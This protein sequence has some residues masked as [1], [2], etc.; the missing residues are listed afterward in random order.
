MRILIADDHALFRNGIR[1]L[2][3]MRGIEV[4]GEA[5][6]GLEA[7]TKARALQPDLV[8]MDLSMPNLNGLDATRVLTTEMP[9]VK[10]VILT[11]SE[12][13]HDLFEAIKC[14]AT[15][16]LT[17]SLEAET[18]FALLEGVSRGEAPITKP[19]ATKILQEFARQAQPRQAPTV[20][21]VEPLTPRERDVIALVA[22]GRTNHEIGERLFLSENT[23]KYHLT[24]ILTKL[25]LN[26]RAEAVAYALR[27]GLIQPPAH[28]A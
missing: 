6:D 10:V 20:G 19:L 24:N 13:E 5:R 9:E 7:L 1:S 3:E 17:K 15:G 11:A 22:Q 28:S 14:G 16:Y 8:L 23:I 12:D 21:P 4:I 27:T 25:H 2:L 26:N 18:F